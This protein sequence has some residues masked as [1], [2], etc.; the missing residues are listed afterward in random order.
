M[1][2]EVSLLFS[3]QPANDPYPESEKS[4]PHHPTLF[5]QDMLTDWL[6]TQVHGA[7]SFLRNK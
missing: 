5:L 3:Q 7:E 6:T 4:S 1:E 2:A